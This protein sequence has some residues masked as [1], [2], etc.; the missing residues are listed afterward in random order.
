ME[1]KIYSPTK[2]QVMIEK[3]PVMRVEEQILVKEKVGFNPYKQKN[4]E[5]RL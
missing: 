4:V 5:F 1:E 2:R 3:Q